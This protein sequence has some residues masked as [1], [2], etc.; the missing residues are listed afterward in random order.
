VPSRAGDAA[1]AALDEA[2]D[3]LMRA[4]Y[5][6]DYGEP[7]AVLEVR[8]LERPE[9]PG[10]GVLVRVHAASIHIGDCHV[11]RGVPKVMRP[12]FGLRRPRSPIPGT[13]IAGTIEAVGTSVT[14]LQPG[15]EV[16]GHC[17]GAFAEYAV[18]KPDGL[19]PRPDNL[20]LEQASAVGVSAHTALQALRDQL[21]VQPGHK[22]LITGASGGVGSFAVQ[23]AKALGAEVTAVC[24]TRNLDLVRSIGADHVIDYTAEDFTQGAERYDRILDNVAAHPMAQTRRV[25]TPDGKLL[26]NGAPVGGWVGGLGNVV[27]ALLTSTVNK[28][29]ARPFVSA[30]TQADALALKELVEAGK[31]TPLIDRSL[32]LDDGA[33]A[34][35]HVAAGH[36]QGKTLITM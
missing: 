34:V 6:E 26:S 20:D 11:I 16:F 1:E 22:V 19:A 32:P 2:R 7:E 17:T 4:L 30:Y 8:Q 13:D 28:Q 15:E 10:D 31:V 23:I 25:L 14:G 3:A 5:Q 12:V 36:A 27:R 33:A 29:Q 35:A 18:A 24:S 9:A 21:Q